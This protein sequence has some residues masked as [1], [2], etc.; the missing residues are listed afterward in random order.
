MEELFNLKEK[1]MSIVEYTSKF[2]DWSR[3]APLPEDTLETRVARFINGLDHLIS[4][5]SVPYEK[6]PIG[7]VHYL[8]FK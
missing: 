2:D 5:S 7:Y 4:D 1:Y 6:E 3:Y 8:S